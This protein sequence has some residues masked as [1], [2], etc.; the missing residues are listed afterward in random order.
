[1]YKAYSSFF[2][3]KLFTNDEAIASTQGMADTVQERVVIKF[4]ICLDRICKGRGGV[5]VVF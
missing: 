4:D 2:N 5:I 3:T 1:M